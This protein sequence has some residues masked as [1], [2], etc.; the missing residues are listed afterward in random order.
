MEETLS[1]PSNTCKGKEVVKTIRQSPAGKDVD[2]NVPERPFINLTKAAFQYVEGYY[3][4]EEGEQPFSLIVEVTIQSW[5]VVDSPT[6]EASP[7]LFR[8][9]LDKL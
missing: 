8:K 2:Q 4:E 5:E 9:K 6:L 1:T 7:R 3:K